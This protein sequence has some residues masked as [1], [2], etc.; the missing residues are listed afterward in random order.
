[1][2]DNVLA[3]AWSWCGGLNKEHSISFQ[4]GPKLILACQNELPKSG[5]KM[6]LALIELI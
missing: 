1:M 3:H 4:S 2:F 6:S 5:A